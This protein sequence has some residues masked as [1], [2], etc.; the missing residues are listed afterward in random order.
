VRAHLVRTLVVVLTLAFAAAACGGDDDDADD[1]TPT[2]ETPSLTG[3][4]IVSGAASL[5]GAFTTIKDD[6][7]EAHPD[8]EVVINLGSSGQLSTQIQDGAPADVAAFADEAPMTALAD[9]GLLE[10]EPQIFAR[11]QLVIVTKPGN[12]KGIE[13][14]D[15]LATAGVIA[16]CADSAPCGEFADQILTTAGV[17]IPPASVTRGQD[18][19]ATLAAV[20]EGDAEAAIV[21]VTDATAA[22]DRVDTVDIPEADNIIATYPVAVIEASTN[23]ELAQAFVD[24]LLGDEGQAVLKDAGFLAP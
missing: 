1:A 23:T 12:P 17:T 15:D 22:G 6:F 19:K 24:H 9:Q 7:V 11:N 14:L 2:T 18:V 13:G 5:T 3:S 21:Y 4:I 20:T 8:A 16:L 10:D